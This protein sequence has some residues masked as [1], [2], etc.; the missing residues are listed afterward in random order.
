MTID[1][2]RDGHLSAIES[3]LST[4]CKLPSKQVGKS[5]RERTVVYK[6]YNF[7]MI[8]IRSTWHYATNLHRQRWNKN[9]TCQPETSSKS[10]R[11]WD[12]VRNKMFQHFFS[13][14]NTLSNL[15]F[16]ILKWFWQHFLKKY[17][18]DGCHVSVQMIKRNDD[19]ERDSEKGGNAR[20]D[21]AVES[22]LIMFTHS[23][24]TGHGIRSLKAFHE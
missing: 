15:R 3:W 1:R 16:N 4:M 20:N 19:S 6:N 5:E 17:S 13:T 18:T 24:L 14:N 8:T 22:A 9:N 23:R 11:W 2:W 7:I 21:I 10:T 12:P